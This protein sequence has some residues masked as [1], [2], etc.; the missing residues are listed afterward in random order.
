ME[1]LFTSSCSDYYYIKS[2]IKRNQSWGFKVYKNYTL[3]NDKYVKF[4]LVYEGTNVEYKKDEYN[5]DYD[6]YITD[7]M[8]NILNIADLMAKGLRLT[9]PEIADRY[10]HPNNRDVDDNGVY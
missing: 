10:R 5:P 9:W 7:F 8:D 2:Q 3:N 4:R 6:R 1:Y